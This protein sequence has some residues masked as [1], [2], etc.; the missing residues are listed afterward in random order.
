MHLAYPAVLSALLFCTGLYGVLARRNAILVL[1]SVELMLNAVNLNLVA[2]DVWLS[3]TAQD[4]LHSGQA[5]TLFT[6]AIAA[7]EV[8][9]GLAIVLAVYR[10]RGTSDID[11]LRDTAET[12]DGSDDGHDASESAA[13]TT[14]EKAEA[15]A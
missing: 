5:L 7:A 15:T 6:I 1:M 12:G 13:S 11:K 14:A 9:I 2:F 3:K 8:G 4:T 10:N